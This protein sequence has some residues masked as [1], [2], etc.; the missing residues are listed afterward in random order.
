M[1]P[2]SDRSLVIVDIDASKG[3]INLWVHFIVA[4]KD[5]NRNGYRRKRYFFWFRLNSNMLN[6]SLAMV[7]FSYQNQSH[8]PVGTLI[9]D[10][11]FF[12]SFTLFLSIKLHFR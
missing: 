2:Q 6:I 8:G 5:I 7:I 10:I 11:F 3:F 9:S 12:K 1:Y 4:I